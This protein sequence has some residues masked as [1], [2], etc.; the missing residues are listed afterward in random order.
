MHQRVYLHSS[1]V[2][3]AYTKTWENSRDTAP[4]KSF[5]PNNSAR[6]FLTPKSPQIA[7]F[8]P[9]KGLH[10]SPSLIYLSTPPTPGVDS[11]LRESH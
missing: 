1:R 7:N 10:T 9:P 3:V 8:K 4:L 11:Q 5:D 6:K 2:H